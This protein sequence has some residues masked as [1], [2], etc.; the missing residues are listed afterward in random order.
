M[1]DFKCSNADHTDRKAVVHC[2]VC[3]A[4]FCGECEKVHPSIVPHHTKYVTRDFSHVSSV[5]QKPEK[6][7]TNSPE[8]NALYKTCYPLCFL[9][10]SLGKDCAHK[11]SPAVP[12]GEEDNLKTFHSNRDVDVAALREKV[13]AMAGPTVA[14]LIKKQDEVGENVAAVKAEVKAVFNKIRDTL[15]AREEELLREV[16]KVPKGLNLSSVIKKINEME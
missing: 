5:P 16:E 9:K 10:C 3:K 14:V 4:C 1:S 15:N 6:C 13:E 8:L 7:P 12:C 2:S 11:G